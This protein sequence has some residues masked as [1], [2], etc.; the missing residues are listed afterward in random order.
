MLKKTILTGLV[1]PMLF[2]CSSID[3]ATGERKDSLEGFNRVMWDFNYNVADPYILKPIASGW[4]NYVPTPVKIVTVNAANNLDEPASFINRLLEGDVKKAFVHFNRFWINSIFGFAGFMDI[5]SNSPELQIQYQRGLGET[6]GHYGVG[7][8]SYVMLPFY[9]PATPRQEIG[10][11][12]ESFYPIA[13]LL[14]PWS[15]AKTGL[16]V[17]DN[18]ANLLDKDSILQQTQDPYTFVREAYF[19][20][21]DF[22]VNDGKPM[23]NSNQL[24]EDILKDID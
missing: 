24:S 20:G 3:P 22:K 21:L 17:I 13:Y 1:L 16:Q 7:T 5:A 18:R 14:S 15:L 9:G 6:F 12:V 19:Q 4:K 2:A 23:T 8:G 11:A 10:K